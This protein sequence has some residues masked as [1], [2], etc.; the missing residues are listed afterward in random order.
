MAPRRQRHPSILECGVI[1]GKPING[2]ANRK[3]A[4]TG[5]REKGEERRSPRCRSVIEAK[6]RRARKQK[7]RTFR[8]NLSR[9]SLR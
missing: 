7:G 6:A 9:G 5:G 2:P 3:H 1:M 4:V 8:T